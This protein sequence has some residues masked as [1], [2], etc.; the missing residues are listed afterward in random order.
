MT[1]NECNMIVKAY[2]NIAI[3]HSVILVRHLHSYE[4]LDDNGQE[5]NCTN[6]LNFISKLFRQNNL[7][8]I[9]IL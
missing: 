4:K 1:M 5:V 8:K 3:I 2:I 9:F 7:I 6:A